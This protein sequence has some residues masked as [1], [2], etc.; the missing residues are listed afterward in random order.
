MALRKNPLS[1]EKA[2]ERLM[3]LCARSEQCESDLER[4]LFNWGINKNDRRAIIDYLIENRF[5]DDARFANSFCRDKAR[6]SYWGPM[7]IKAELIKRKI[8]QS[9]IKEALQGVE[10]E[11]WK[12]ALMKAGA[13][14]AK[15]LDLTGAGGYADSQKLFRYL[16]S[17]GFNSSSASKAVAHMKKMQEEKDD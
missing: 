11:I 5:L 17:R 3:S 15:S 16:I 1:K 13:S 10:M 9:L 14:K 12:N 8:K 7:K 6:F 4:K 2:L